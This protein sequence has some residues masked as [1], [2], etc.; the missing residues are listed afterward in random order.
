MCTT[1]R[2]SL[3]QEGWS[4]KGNEG[5]PDGSHQLRMIRV[6]YWV[7][8]QQLGLSWGWETDVGADVPPQGQWNAVMRL[9]NSVFLKRVCVRA[10][11]HMSVQ[12]YF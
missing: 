1:Q 2:G 4:D 10:S 5:T 9:R 6:I 7:W 12:V 8:I 11:V 3:R